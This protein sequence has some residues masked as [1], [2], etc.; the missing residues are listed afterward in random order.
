[1]PCIFCGE[2]LREDTKVEHLIPRPELDSALQGRKR[3][4]ISPVQFEMPHV[5]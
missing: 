4:R 5:G 3:L 1:M 2:E